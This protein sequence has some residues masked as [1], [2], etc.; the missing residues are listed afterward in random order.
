M[1][2]DDDGAGLLP[3][4]KLVGFADSAHLTE[5]APTNGRGSSYLRI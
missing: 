5:R 2:D 3:V 1:T 4:A